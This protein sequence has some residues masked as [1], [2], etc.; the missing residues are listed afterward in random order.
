MKQNYTVKRLICPES[1]LINFQAPSLALRP[2][3]A[4]GLKARFFVP[5][6]HGEA[7]SGNP[8]K[9]PR[10]ILRAVLGHSVRGYAIRPLPS[11][12]RL[13]FID[14]AHKTLDLSYEG[15]PVKLACQDRGGGIRGESSEDLCDLTGKSERS[16]GFRARG[17]IPRLTPRSGPRG[18]ERRIWSRPITV[19]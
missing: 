13:R 18:P 16:V 15:S 8:S 2:S 12:V 17:H 3:K 4:V 7:P 5:L 11:F 6:G 19:A 14:G 9:W 1:G 10:R